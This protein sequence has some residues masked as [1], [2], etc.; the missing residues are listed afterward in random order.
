MLSYKRAV[1]RTYRRKLDAPRALTLIEQTF[2]T[3]SRQKNFRRFLTEFFTVNE[4]DTFAQRLRIAWFLH[5]GHSFRLI[6]DET[7]ASF[8]TIT[9]LDRWL[10]KQNPRYRR[11]I[12]LHR[13]RHRKHAAQRFPGDR[14]LPGSIKAFTRSLLG[15]DIL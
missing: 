15:T 6:Q 4:R 5:A 2:H 12:P 3:A 11:I 13:H 1:S 14:P 9:T 7:G 10:K 8:R